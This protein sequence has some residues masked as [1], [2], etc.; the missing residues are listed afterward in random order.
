MSRTYTT[1]RLA[2]ADALTEKL[3]DI[4][5][6]GDTNGHEIILDITGGGSSYTINQSG[7]NDNKVDATFSG[8][9][10]TVNI[11]QSD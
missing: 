2:I 9:G 7:V 11:T 8:D 4:D 5:G 1:R 10:Q 6:N 3:K